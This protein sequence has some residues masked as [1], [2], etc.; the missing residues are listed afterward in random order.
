MLRRLIGEDIHLVSRHASDESRVRV[1]RSQIE[2]VILNLVLNARDAMPDGGTLT[3]STGMVG[4]EDL[5]S[6]AAQQLEPGPYVCL[7]VA[8][9][10]AGMSPE[11]I[12]RAFDPFFTTKEMGKGTGLGLSTV[13]GIVLQSG[14]AVWIESAPGAGTTVRVCLPAAPEADDERGPELA[15]S[16]AAPV[17]G[18]ILVVEDEQAVRELVSRTLRGAGYTVLEAADGEQGLDI[19]R[20]AAGAIDLLVTDVVMPRLGGPQLRARLEALSPGIPALF[21]SGYAD[22]TIPPQ[23]RERSSSDLILKPFTPAALLERVR[24]RLAVS[25]RSRLS[26]TGC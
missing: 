16:A 4:W 23:D 24:H 7:S 3:I 12:E 5:R 20:H 9:T 1:D 11:V 2:Q 14:G 21:I 8:D 22:E 26:T 18:T 17:A 10:G 13:H 19:A 15:T 25:A 6:P